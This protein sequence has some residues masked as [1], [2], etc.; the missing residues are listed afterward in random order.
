MKRLFFLPLLWLSIMAFGQQ[1]VVKVEVS[2]DT[3]SIGELVEVTYT[4]ENGEGK[5]LMPDISNLPVIRGPNTSSSFMYQNGKMSSNQSYSFTLMA[6]E[7]GTLVIPAAT[8]QT[9]E[10]KLTINPVEVVV[11]ATPGAPSSSKPA[12]G[13]SSSTITREKRKF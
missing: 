6:M 2:S 1:P 4:I 9:G 5:L 12:T 10:E 13:K 3:I 7:A 8:Y 11:L